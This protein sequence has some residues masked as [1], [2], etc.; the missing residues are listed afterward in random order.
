MRDAPLSMACERRRWPI[1]RPHVFR[2]GRLWV[3]K[4]KD[5]TGYGYSVRAACN[6]W[7]GAL[8]SAHAAPRAAP[9]YLHL[10][11]HVAQENP[12]VSHAA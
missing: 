7:N 2:D 6:E 1:A 4:S 5:A 10:G 3:C 11:A 8:T 12:H 9:L